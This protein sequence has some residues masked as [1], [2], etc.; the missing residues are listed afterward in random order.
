MLKRFVVNG[1][2]NTSKVDISFN[3]S[4]VDIFIGENGLGKTTILNIM[5]FSL[6]KNYQRLNRYDFKSIEIHFDSGDIARIDHDEIN[7]SRNENERIDI[8]RRIP[9]DI[10]ELFS[11]EE[12][13]ELVQLV[14]NKAL[15]REFVLSHPALRRNPLARRYPSSAIHQMIIEYVENFYTENMR[16]Y[17]KLIDNN[18]G[19]VKILYF[20]TFRRIEEDLKNL[21]IGE[22]N[23]ITEPNDKLIQFGMEDVKLRFSNIKEKIQRLSSMGLANISKE[24]LSQLIKGD[25]KIE[26]LNVSSMNPQSIQIILD[27][28]GPSFSEDDKKRIIDKINSNKITEENI[29]LIYFIRKLIDVYEQQKEVDEKIKHFTELCNKYLKFSNKSIKYIENEVEFYIESPYFEERKILMDFLSSMSSGEK[30]ILSLFSKIYL[31]EEEEYIILFDEPELS[32]SIFWQELLLPDILNSKKI[33]SLIAVT[34][35]PFIYD[36]ELKEYASGLSDH[37]S[38]AGGA[39]NETC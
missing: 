16:V 17:G 26:D 39:W 36:N 6:M 18:I 38:R 24:I 10:N 21:N 30:Q 2:F 15:R 20:P 5:Y 22:E 35:S 3:D 23:Y 7:Y 32:L 25:P 29:F 27:R 11:P 19:N 8:Q 1:L 9:I 13:D 12:I 33:Q 4:G 37:I 31:L 14:E 28:I 34:H